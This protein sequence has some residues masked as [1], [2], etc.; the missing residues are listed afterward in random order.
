MSETHTG[1]RIYAFDCAYDGSSWIDDPSSLLSDIQAAFS[2]ITSI[3]YDQLK[4]ANIKDSNG[5][6]A[7][8]EILGIKYNS[9][10]QLTSAEN[11]QLIGIVN[12]ALLSTTDLYFLYINIC[13]DVFVDDPSVGWP[14]ASWE[15]DN[16][17]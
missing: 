14:N 8:I 9:K 16:V 17:N 6:K 12:T 11:D 7:E 15:T 3:T 10:T 2:I 13:N 5:K 1:L 4:V